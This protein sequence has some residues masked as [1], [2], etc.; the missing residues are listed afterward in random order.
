MNAVTTIVKGLQKFVTDVNDPKSNAFGITNTRGQIVTRE[1]LAR[2]IQC[3]CRKENRFVLNRKANFEYFMSTA[4]LGQH[5]TDTASQVGH[6]ASLDETRWGDAPRLM[7][8]ARRKA[9]K[10]VVDAVIANKPPVLTIDIV[11]P[12]TAEVMTEEIIGSPATEAVFESALPDES[13]PTV[14][15][16]PAGTPTSEPESSD[17]VTSKPLGKKEAAKHARKLA[18][19]AEKQ[20]Q[21]KALEATAGD[22]AV[23]SAMLQ[24]RRDVEM[25]VN[26]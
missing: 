19:I 22:P 25:I 4:W 8:E 5:A 20:A 9:G 21:I 16:I 1:Y 6:C 7:R 12:V 10:Q 14:E 15:F 18:V 17:P 23:D 3:W 11:D 13:Q 26:G 2:Y 24:L